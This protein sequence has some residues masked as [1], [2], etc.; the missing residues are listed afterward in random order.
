VKKE[1]EKRIHH[2]ERRAQSAKIRDGITHEKSAKKLLSIIS[3]RDGVK[4]GS[5]GE[6]RRGPTTEA[7]RKEER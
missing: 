7:T 6:D 2:A 4:N 1:R 5:R 3:E